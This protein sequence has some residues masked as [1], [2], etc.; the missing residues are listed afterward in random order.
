MPAQPKELQN[1]AFSRPCGVPLRRQAGMKGAEVCGDSHS[2]SKHALS[3]YKQDTAR[4]QERALS[5]S[6]PPSRK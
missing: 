5:K 4:H 1:R 6:Q 2:F 3:M